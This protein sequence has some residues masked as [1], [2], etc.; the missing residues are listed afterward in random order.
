MTKVPALTTCKNIFKDLGVLTF[1]SLIMEE[2]S[3]SVKRNLTTFELMTE[4]HGY[5]TRQKRKK[6][7]K[8]TA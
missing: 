7:N 4:S 1:P 6:K 5:K 3:H 2:C 8:V